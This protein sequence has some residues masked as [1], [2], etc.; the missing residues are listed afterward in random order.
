MDRG[1]LETEPTAT[2]KLDA[3]LNHLNDNR[4]LAYYYCYGLPRRYYKPKDILL[5]DQD[6][7]NVLD[8][9]L[10]DKMVRMTIMGIGN[11]NSNSAEHYCISLDGE[12][13]LQKGGYTQRIK[14]ENIEIRHTRIKDNL[15]VI[16]SIIAAVST[17]GLLVLG[18]LNS[19]CD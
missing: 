8:K 11:G 18:I 9:L 15:L 16:F 13:L 5:T 19:F 14:N 12:M 6:L 7:L 2:E 3:V 1:R 10:R 4:D 17:C